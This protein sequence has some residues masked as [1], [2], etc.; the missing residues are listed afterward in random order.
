MA[1]GS[2]VQSHRS[3]PASRFA[4]LFSLCL[5]GH[6]AAGLTLDRRWDE[7]CQGLPVCLVLPATDPCHVVELRLLSHSYLH[8]FHAMS[9]LSPR[10]LS[11]RA[12]I[13]GHDCSV[14]AF[15]RDDHATLVPKSY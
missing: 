14:A 12:S 3:S 7:R 8:S 13:P 15:D 1:C 2:L 6:A 5:W 10:H 9:H 11:R 4:Y